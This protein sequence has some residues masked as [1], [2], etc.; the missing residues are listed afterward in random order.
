MEVGGH[1]FKTSNLLKRYEIL[2]LC[3]KETF[4]NQH[5]QMNTFQKPVFGN[6]ECRNLHNVRH[7][8]GARLAFR[9]SFFTNCDI[10]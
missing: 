2:L 6:Q 3:Q 7:R 1:L 4:E 10:M 8:T 5:F 9:S